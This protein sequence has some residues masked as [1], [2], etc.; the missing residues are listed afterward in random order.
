MRGPTMK[1]V[2]VAARVSKALVSIVFR[3]EP[4]A[5]DETR[6]HV[7]AAANAIGY[8]HNR[9]ASRLARSRT[10]LIG[11]TLTLR[12]SF[13]AELV[14]DIQAE[15]DE[16]GYEIAFGT[17][18][19][20]HD[21]RRA[22]DTLLE[23]RCEALILLGPEMAAAELMA[24]GRQLPTVVMG[25]PKVPDVVDVVRTADADGIGRAVDHLVEL[26]HRRIVHVDGGTGPVAAPR[27]NGYRAAMRRHGLAD[28]IRV[29][30]GSYTEEG[31]VAAATGLLA[32]PSLPTAI[33]AA[34]DRSAIGIIDALVRAGVRIPEDVSIVGYD[35]SPL[36]RL[37]HLNLTT[38]SQVP[39]EQARHAIDL[40]V[41]RLDE[42]RTESRE[43]VL[44]P[45]LVIRATT[46]APA[47]VGI[48][49]VPPLQ[50][51]PA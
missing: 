39:R 43:V 31:G 37:G 12:N 41:Q 27:R 22:I 20:T 8:R 40:A 15:A 26:G 9:T 48:P 49:P 38:V 45:S 24:L 50:A 3:G 42:G 33:V 16:A 13:H 2:A 18:T 35:D 1:D 19:R 36:A 21:E 30:P 51:E 7:F 10:R 11:V 47:F 17:M 29:V 46:A 34:N 14:E 6:A 23:F 4:G 28:L 32:E 25:R 5:S 44:Q